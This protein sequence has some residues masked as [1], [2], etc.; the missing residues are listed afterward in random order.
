MAL[1]AGEP[2]EKAAVEPWVA[3]V[4]NR[5]CTGTATPASSRH[6]G[7]KEKDGMIHHHT[8]WLNRHADDRRPT[9]CRRQGGV[10]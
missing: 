10:A 4:R 2:D 6:A 7:H 1:V 3:P 5:G 8:I 9:R